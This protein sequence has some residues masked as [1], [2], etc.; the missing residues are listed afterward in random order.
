LGFFGGSSFSDENNKT[1]TQRESTN[2]PSH[3]PS[4]SGGVARIGGIAII[5]ITS[6]IV[7]ASI[8]SSVSAA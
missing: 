4:N 7:I 6:L 8:V 2:R 5:V 1:E 3:G